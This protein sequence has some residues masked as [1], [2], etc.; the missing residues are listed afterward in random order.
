MHFSVLH[1]IGLQSLG[2]AEWYFP[3][4]VNY[5]GQRIGGHQGVFLG[6]KDIHPLIAANLRGDAISKYRKKYWGPIKL[7]RHPA[8]IRAGYWRRVARLY[9]PGLALFWNQLRSVREAK[10]AQCGGLKAVYWERGTGWHTSYSNIKA[11]E[12]LQ[13]VD[14]VLANSEAGKRI[15][16]ARG[17]DREI[18]ICRNGVRP[19]IFDRISTPRE[20]PEGGVFRLG[21]AARLVPYKGVALAIHAVKDLVGRGLE[22]RLSIAGT[23]PDLPALRGLA[24]ALAIDDRVVFLGVVD[25]M[26]NYF[27]GIDCLVHPALCEPSSNTVAEAICR[28]CPVVA[29]NVDGMPEVMA[30]GCGVLVPATLCADDYAELGVDPQGQPPLVFH[31]DV[32]RV[33]EPLAPSPTALAEGVMALASSRDRYAAASRACIEWAR[34]TFDPYRRYQELVD[35]LRSVW[36]H[37]P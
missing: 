37:R 33:G 31:P 29:T 4:C 34:G 3:E 13:A 6:N 7:P 30:A 36:I 5:I 14:S 26:P 20:A 23:G 12:M 18:H 27:D 2:G 35:V 24:K 8:A 1:F 15:L 21:L 32:G 10:A 22:C 9:H 16:R 19:G 28:G 25:D 11:V 17:F